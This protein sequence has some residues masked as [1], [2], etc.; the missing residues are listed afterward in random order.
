MAVILLILASI[1]EIEVA[2]DS[3]KR[4]LDLMAL[5]GSEYLS[6]AD[7]VELT[8]VQF[9]LDHRHQRVTLFDNDH[10][11]KITLD[12]S[13]YEHDG[14]WKKMMIPLTMIG[15]E[16][17]I[18]R[19][20]VTPFFAENFE[21]LVF[22]K[23]SIS[24]PEI[25]ALRIAQK[26]DSISLRFVS[27]EELKLI[28]G[29]EA[30]SGSIEVDGKLAPGFGFPKPKGIIKDLKISQFP[31]YV[32][33]RLKLKSQDFS[34]IPERK[35]ITI[36]PKARGKVN[37]IVIDPGHGGIDPGAI[38]RIGTYEKSL[39]LAIAK[40]LK[41]II[42]KNTKIRVIM[43]RT[44]DRYL[45]L[46]RR[47][48]IAN[49]HKADLFISIHCNASRRKK[50]EGFEVYFLSEAKTSWERAVAARENASIRFDLPEGKFTS[51]LEYIFWDLA[52][53]QFLEE[54][55]RLA[56]S[57][58]DA[59][60]EDI[61]IKNRGVH[62]ARFYVLY[63]CFMPSILVE[64]GFVSNEK[65]EKVLRSSSF[66]EKMAKAI[67]MGINAYIKKRGI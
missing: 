28:V 45:S 63:G 66:Q 13:I 18:E 37:L 50:S 25:E 43:T 11:V 65:E 46:S 20:Q 57:I 47:A 12:V 58:Q 40:R 7:V 6:L 24:V 51:E 52:Q 56:E 2:C 21:K 48:T 10:L 26:G 64:C 42:E 29:F 16:I 49:R 32:K 4:I 27:D 9:I 1:G 55:N 34:F 38:G 67:Y 30:D 41:E 33:V 62:Q 60:C 61:K 3:E 54:S 8:G 14:V 39:N 31:D 17:A 22:L 59:V 36:Y 23:E 15:G 19:S 44:S 5:G 35:M 53:A